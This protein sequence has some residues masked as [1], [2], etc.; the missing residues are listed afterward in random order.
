M[1]FSKQDPP[2]PIDAFKNLEPILESEPMALAT[3]STSAPVLSQR[4]EILL[5]EE[6][7]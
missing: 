1:S 3:S 4:A 7:L 6:T 5:M 2:K